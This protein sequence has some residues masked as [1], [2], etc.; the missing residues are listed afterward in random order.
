[1]KPPNSP[2]SD[3]IAAPASPRC[4]FSY[5]D[6]R[7]CRMLCRPSHPSLCPF[8]AREE[9]QIL[10]AGKIAAGFASITGGFYTFNDVNQAL[11]TLFRVV[12]ANRI[13]PRSA[14]TLAYLGQLLLQSIPGVERE[15]NLSRGKN[16]WRDMLTFVLNPRSKPKD[17]LVQ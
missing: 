13:P 14:V 15:I 10:E 3:K 4:A 1:V 2:V 6:G 5:S 17:G 7:R 9:L 16:G 12:A 8:H 11:G